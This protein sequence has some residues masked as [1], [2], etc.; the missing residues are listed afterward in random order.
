MSPSTETSFLSALYAP[1]K[2][3][4]YIRISQQSTTKTGDV[5]DVFGLHQSK[6]SITEENIFKLIKM[7]LVIIFGKTITGTMKIKGGNNAHTPYL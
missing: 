2:F 1:E 6:I 7:F 5:I 4:S 3:F